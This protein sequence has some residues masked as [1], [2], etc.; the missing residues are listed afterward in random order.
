MAVSFFMPNVVYS[1]LGWWIIFQSEFLRRGFPKINPSPKAI[2]TRLDQ[3][4]NHRWPR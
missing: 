4:A 3:Y 2:L 1:T